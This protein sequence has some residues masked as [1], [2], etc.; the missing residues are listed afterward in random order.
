LIYS[1]TAAL[2]SVANFWVSSWASGL[3]IS[4]ITFPYPPSPAIGI[5]ARNFS[6]VKDCKELS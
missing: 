5:S 6:Y 1:S 2:T 3:L 4:G